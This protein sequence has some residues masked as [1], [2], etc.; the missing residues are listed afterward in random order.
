MDCPV[1]DSTSVST[2][3]VMRIH[4]IALMLATCATAHADFEQC[5]ADLSVLALSEGI[6]NQTVEQVF[7]DVQQIPRVIANDRAQPEF[8]QTFT[9]YYEQRVTRRRVQE[10][11]RKL[12]QHADLLSTIQHQSGVPAQYLVALWG[13]ETNFGAYFGKLSIPSALATLAC[14]DR[15][16]KFFQ[17]EFLAVLQI[18]DRGDIA[19]SALTGSWAGA[20][21]HMQFMPSTFLAHA[22]D[23][24]GD[25]RRDLMG[26]L[27]D[28]LTSGA[29]YLG[30]LGWQTGYR[31]GREVLLDADFDYTLAGLD[32]WQPVSAWRELGMTDVFSKPLPDT[33][34]SAALLVPTGHQGPAF[35][36]YPNFRVIMGWNR[37]EAYALAVGHLADR[38]SGAGRLHKRLPAIEDLRLPIKEVRQLQESLTALGFDAGTPDGILGPGTRKAVSAFQDAN[39]LIADGYP[40]QATRDLL[41]NQ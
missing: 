34:V 21:G 20:I 15:R 7:A 2:R 9:E 4:L 36:V 29:S 12:R 38:I 31:W 13:L 1:I 11:R 30:S 14:D 40:D 41:F 39:D 19:P 5:K 32:G 10:G 28:A 23:A 35:L 22:V 17:R 3:N 6:S 25:G 18:V 24:D 37:S 33:D 8:T 27:P 16:P 26:N